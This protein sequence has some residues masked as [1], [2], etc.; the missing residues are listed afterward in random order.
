MLCGISSCFRLLFP[1]HRQVAHALLTRPPLS[2]FLHS[3]R[4]ECVMHAA[5]VHP[6]PGS[7]SL[8]CCIRSPLHSRIGLLP[9]LQSFC[10]CGFFLKSDL[11][12]CIKE[13]YEFVVLL[14]S[15]K[16]ALYFLLL[17]N[18]Q[19]PTPSLFRT[20]L[21]V[22]HILSRLSRG[23][24]KKVSLF[25]NFFLS[26]PLRLPDSLPILPHYPIFVKGVRQK[27]SDFSSSPSEGESFIHFFPLLD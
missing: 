25:S 19:G 15:F 8:K 18:F 10:F 21:P 14:I 3:V 23:F 4:L 2:A 13:L 1:S 17:F 20:A 24:L 9:F 12:F 16:L 6:E 27:K 7:N 11:L 26:P 5:S 22:Y